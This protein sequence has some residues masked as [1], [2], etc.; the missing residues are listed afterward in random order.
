LRHIKL[1]VFLDRGGIGFLLALL[2][3]I[4]SVVISG[5]GLHILCLGILIAAS[6]F[7][8]ATLLQGRKKTLRILSNV[9]GFLCFAGGVT[10]FALTLQ[11]PGLSALPGNLYPKAGLPTNELK[12][13]YLNSWDLFLAKPLF[14]WGEGSFR[15]MMTF[16]QDVNIGLRAFEAAHSDLLESLVERGLVGTLAW[17]VVPAFVLIKFLRLPVKR[18]LSWYLFGTCCLALVLALVGFPFQLPAFAF[19]F[20][21]LWFTAYRWSVI[22]H[23]VVQQPV[24]S[25]LAFSERELRQRIDRKPASPSK[26]AKPPN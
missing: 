6:C 3:L 10:V 23:L 7:D 15:T 17:W 13:L 19:S 26:S 20:W 8:Y 1:R 25:N 2:I 22:P 12:L 24:G 14:G 4:A 11:Q 5:T 21:L 18:P 16:T 9:V